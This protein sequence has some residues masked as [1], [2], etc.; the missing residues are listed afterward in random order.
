ASF[1]E[2]PP[3]RLGAVN[4]G[5]RATTALLPPDQW[6]N[7]RGTTNTVPSDWLTYWWDTPVR[8]DGLGIQF[9]RDSNWIRPPASWTVEYLDAVGAWRPLGASDPPAVNT[10][11]GVSFPPVT[12]VAL[13]ATFTGLENG[14]YVHSVA[15][16]EWEVYG[17]QADALPSVTVQT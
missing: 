6:G 7:Y 3:M 4:D 2:Q 8:V 12:T 9:H 16:S 5:F 1:T 15:A 10:W 17:V 14:P 13:R 11:H